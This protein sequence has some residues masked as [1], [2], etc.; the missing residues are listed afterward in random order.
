META[1]Q[2]HSEITLDRI[3]HPTD[4]SP[5]SEVA[6]AHA[7]KLATHQQG[8]LTMLHTGTP[9]GGEHWTDFPKVRTALERWGFLPPHSHHEDVAQLGLSVAKI[10]A[11][12]ENP[13]AGTLE[14]L[15]KHPHDMI[16]LATHQ[17]DGLERWLHRAVAEPIARQA[18]ELALFVPHNADGFVAIESGAVNLR[19]VLIPVDHNP[20]PQMALEVAAAL[21]TSLHCAQVNFIVLH[22]GAGA[23]FP[24]VR[25]P[26][27]AA[28]QPYHWRKVVKEG[29]VEEAILATAHEC[30]ADLIVM[31]TAGRH[32]FLDALRGSTTERIVRTAE[33]PVL[34]VPPPHPEV[35]QLHD[36]LA[37]QPN[38]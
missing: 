38:F 13:V 34:A 17:Y 22:V 16:V 3:F 27:S 20:A 10:S 23:T 28:A 37:W 12:E 24:R 32:G 6:F 11:F 4:F 35:R 15:G 18:G 30:K 19:S 25:I 33:I 8:R 2:T 14:Y 26:A 9:R 5:T 7:L 1:T 21:A 36:A 29:N 31:S